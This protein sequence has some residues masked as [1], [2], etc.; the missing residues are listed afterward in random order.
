[1]ST[2]FWDK[3]EISTRKYL[4]VRYAGGPIENYEENGQVVTPDI[5]ESKLV[6]ASFHDNYF[7]ATASAEKHWRDYGL[8]FMKRDTVFFFVV[9]VDSTLEVKPG[10]ILDVSVSR[11]N[12]PKMG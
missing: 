10:S 6:V 11:T 5:D 8:N 4:A 2:T 12:V 1:M 7:K 9:E 3:T